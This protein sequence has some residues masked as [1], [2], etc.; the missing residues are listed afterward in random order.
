MQTPL[1]MVI[2]LFET[3]SFFRT[4][5]IFERDLSGATISMSNSFEGLILHDIIDMSLSSKKPMI[6][7]RYVSM[8]LTVTRFKFS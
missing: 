6:L 5:A 7:P 4:D 3:V 1:L 2:T 8:F